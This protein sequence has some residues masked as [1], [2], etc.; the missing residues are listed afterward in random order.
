LPRND[1]VVVLVTCGSRKEARC[2]AQALVNKRLA[3]CVTIMEAPV[4]SVYRWKEKV[5][6]AT[7]Y[8][9]LIK[10]VRR[11]LPRARSAVVDLHSYEV[12]EFIALPV[13]AGSPAYLKWLDD[14]LATRAPKPDRGR[15]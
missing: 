10:T 9:L 6:S 15:R 1:K 8:L 5:Q 12:P 13:S 2:I 4:R 7:E 11:L 14:C 3:A